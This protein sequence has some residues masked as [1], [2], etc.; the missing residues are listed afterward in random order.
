MK[1]EDFDFELPE[2]LIAQTPIEKR[3]ASRMLILDKNPG[4]ITPKHFSDI[5]DYL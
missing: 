4:E 3:D 1:T 2:R 5:I